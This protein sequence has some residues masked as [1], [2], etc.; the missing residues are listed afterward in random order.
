MADNSKGDTPTFT[1]PSIPKKLLVLRLVSL[2]LR[3]RNRNLT[4]RKNK[5]DKN[6]LEKSDITKIIKSDSCVRSNVQGIPSDPSSDS[7]P[8]PSNQPDA[9]LV[10]P[11]PGSSTVEDESPKTQMPPAPL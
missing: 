8:G 11:A 6:S 5:S 3:L 10:T 7:I 1:E 2:L 9:G 4:Q